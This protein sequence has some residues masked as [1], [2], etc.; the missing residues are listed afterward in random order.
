MIYYGE[1]VGEKGMDNEGFSGQ[2]GRT[3]IF[4]WWSIPSVRRLRKVIASGAY[5]TLE[6]SE[7]V[8]AGMKE[9][10]AQVFIRFASALRVA[11]QDDAILKGST[12]DLWY[13]NY[14]SEG[15][16][17]NRHYA[18]LRDYNDHTLLVAANFSDHDADMQLI[19]PPH[20]FEWMEMPRTENFNPD[21]PVQVK[22]PAHDAVLITLL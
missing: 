1:E 16:D 20:A 4:D 7:L 22:V 13:C 3:S 10:E 19:I 11:S 6:V 15:F 9:D 8:K 21:T 14:S 17:K 18:F 2:D 5:K 12:Y